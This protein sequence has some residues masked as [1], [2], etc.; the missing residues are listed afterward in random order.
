MRATSK[1]AG[2]W[3]LPCC[4]AAALW[5]FG[6]RAQAHIIDGPE[7]PPPSEGGGG[8]PG[9]GPTAPAPGAPGDGPAPPPGGGGDGG[10]GGGEGGGAGGEDPGTPPGNPGGSDGVA[11]PGAD[12]RLGTDRADVTVAEIDRLDS[13]AQQVTALADVLGDMLQSLDPDLRTGDGSR[14]SA[15]GLADFYRDR[16]SDPEAVLASLE[17]AERIGNSGGPAAVAPGADPESAE[18]Q[19]L[20][21][22]RDVLRQAVAELRDDVPSAVE[23]RLF[24]NSRTRWM[25]L[26]LIVAAL[27]AAGWFA[28]TRLK[29]RQPVG[30][31]PSLSR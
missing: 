23:A 31:R 24:A 6:P 4:V 26:L 18:A 5:A 22:A 25:W 2:R 14:P 12:G 29:L 11:S 21:A 9:P 20:A 3:L 19:E 16:L 13:A 8:E 15:R 10:G 7:D 1:V 27:A 17:Q 30:R 28:W